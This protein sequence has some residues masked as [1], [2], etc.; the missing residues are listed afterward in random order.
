MEPTTKNIIVASII[1]GLVLCGIVYISY[2]DKPYTPP[3]ILNQENSNGNKLVINPLDI[4]ITPTAP[5]L[6]F[7]TSAEAGENT[8]LFSTK[9]LVEK[10]GEACVAAA[11]PSGS[12]IKV[13]KK[14]LKDDPNVNW[15]NKESEIKKA[16][17]ALDAKEFADFY[18][19]YMGPQAA[20]S[21]DK[22]V[23]ALQTATI[24]LVRD[25]LQTSELITDG[26]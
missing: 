16:V 3:S 11:S 8:V 6:M 25:A 19:I 21:P 2:K 4:Q 15:W 18:I 10:G 20:C 12:Y 23:G 14:D 22:E 13:F 5:D 1:T 26:N 17:A 9:T 24:K 7:T